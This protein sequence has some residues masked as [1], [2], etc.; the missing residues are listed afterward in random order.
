MRAAIIDACA[1]INLINSGNANEILAACGL[2]V[3]VQGLV[4][5]EIVSGAGI[6]EAL[7][8]QGLIRRYDGTNLQASRV[9]EI[10]IAHDLGVGEAE[11]IAIC[12]EGGLKLISDDK[13]ARDAATETLGSG[14]V[15][16]MIGLLCASIDAGALTP[17]LAAALLA[18]AKK[19]GGFL[20]EFDFVTRSLVA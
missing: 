13:R 4:E 11:C 20:P 2:E 18:Q 16:G 10:I 8:S 5:D 19:A 3:W 12:I 1:L 7:I 9:S 14:E 6:L 17:T 15:V